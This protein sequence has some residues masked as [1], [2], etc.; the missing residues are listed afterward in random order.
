[1][2]RVALVACSKTKRPA[3][4]EA[5][6]LYDSRLF[7]LSWRWACRFTD[8][9]YIV[10]ALH[11]VVSPTKVIAPYDRTIDELHG[12]DLE[13]WIRGIE[14]WMF[15]H[16]RGQAVTFV[17]LAGEKYAKHL[18]QIIV[19]RLAHRGRQSDAARWR[20][21]EPL[22]HMQIGERLHFLTTADWRLGARP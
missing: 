6:K 15:V 12:E 7:R 10:S 17:V 22:G 2:K 5:W 8:E 3:P 18:R 21:Q 13:G 19:H 11:G 16:F 9:Q 1:M 20:M 14:S 4:M